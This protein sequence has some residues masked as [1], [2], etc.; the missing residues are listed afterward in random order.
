MP[1]VPL[2]LGPLALLLAGAP[3][4]VQTVPP[5][6]A[7]APAEPQTPAEELAA[8]IV[9]LGQIEGRMTVPVRIADAGP[10]NFVID[11]GAE[12]T[13]I[14]RE[15]ARN[16]RLPAG[17]EVNVIAMSGSARVGTYVIP[18]I[19]V[20][21]V[22]DIGTIHAPALNA[23]H[24]G[25]LGL[26]GIDMLRDHAVVIDFD[27]GTMSVYPSTKRKRALPRNRN[28]IV[29]RAK[30]LFGQLIVTDAMFADQPIRVV[31]DTGSPISVGNSA[32][33]RLVRRSAG[34]MRPL[35]LTSAIGGT[36]DTDYAY[37]S[38]IRVGDIRFGDMPVAFADVVPFERFGLDDRPAMLLG[39]NSLK[40]FRQV[41]IDF[42]NREVRFLLPRR[43]KMGYRCNTIVA[44]SC[45]G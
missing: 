13:V 18:S 6:P 41:R 27:A 14:S 8:A 2:A 29:V 25:G 1:G 5:P 10:Y 34:R 45:A 39:M 21:S 40:Y 4:D 30:S 43:E 20:S 12:R 22:P 7:A 3:S 32:L 33:R 36:V 26:V 44:R 28:E 17:R 31:I 15:L 16:L 37:V 23:L 9:A 38:D 19:R 24:L 35:A 11:T 42:A